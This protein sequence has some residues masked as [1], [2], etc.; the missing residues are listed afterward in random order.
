MNLSTSTVSR[1]LRDSYEIS[2]ET[3]PLVI[4]CAERF[5]YRPNPIALSLQES[6]SRVI[7]VIVPQIANNFFSEVINGIEAAAHRRGYF[8][9]IFQSH[10]S[11]ERE[12]VTVQQVVNRKAD[13]LLILLYHHPG[14]RIA[15]GF[16]QHRRS[17][18]AVSRFEY[19]PTAC[20]G[21]WPNS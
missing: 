7:G 21:N 11:Y 18:F 12:L 3:K 20:P 5:N 17:G 8:V 14:N 19:G 1:A 4:D 16:Y 10:E 6:R 15:G 9:F 2:P 13:G